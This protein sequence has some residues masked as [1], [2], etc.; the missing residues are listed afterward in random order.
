MKKTKIAGLGV[1]VLVVVALAGCNLFGDSR[2]PGFGYVPVEPPVARSVRGTGLTSNSLTTSV[3]S[4]EATFGGFDSLTDADCIAEDGM[5]PE[6]AGFCEYRRLAGSLSRID[7]DMNELNRRAQ[8]NGNPI[9]VTSDPQTVTLNL[10][11]MSIDGPESIAT[12]IQC[13]EIHTNDLNGDPVDGG[14]VFLYATLF[15]LD[16][17]GETF[18]LVEVQDMED[19]RGPNI[20]RSLLISIASHNRI[21]DRVE[22]WSFSIEDENE[23]ESTAGS[24]AEP[25]LGW[26]MLASQIIATPDTDETRFSLFATRDLSSEERLDVTIN[27][28]GEAAMRYRDGNADNDIGDDPTFEFIDSNRNAIIAL[29]T[30]VRGT[31]LNPSQPIGLFTE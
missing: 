26:A 25:L 10:P 6:I 7:D 28:E 29:Y 17:A 11:K 20:A 22:V 27:G 18:Y 1:I 19:E 31:A 5:T 12:E 14:R 16:E 24:E 4:P 2:G 9:C 13:R 8:D 21:S 23:N 3:G 15:G 30:Q